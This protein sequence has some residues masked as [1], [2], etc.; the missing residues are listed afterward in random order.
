M[1]SSIPTP[2]TAGSAVCAATSKRPRAGLGLVL[3]ASGIEQ[4]ARLAGCALVIAGTALAGRCLDVLRA[5]AT[6]AARRA[7]QNARAVRRV[8]ATL[9]ALKGV[10]AKAGQFAALRHDLLPES[11]TAALAELRDRVPPLPFA[12]I[13]NTVENEL[14]APIEALFLEFERQPLGAASLA[15]VH[16]ARLPSGQPVAVKVQYPW[17]RAS[18]PAD[19]A[20]IRA[21][22]RA[23]TCRA[24]G[25]DWRRIVQEFAAGIADELDFRREARIA[26]EIAGNLARDPKIVVPEPIHSHTTER[27][28][29]MSY[30]PAVSVSDSARL[31]EMG[32][33]PT[34]VLEILARAYAKQVFADGLFHA[35]PHPGNLFVLDEPTAA[36][37]PRVLFIDFGLCRRLDPVLRN[38]MRR[39]IHALIQRDSDGF[40]D[41]MDRMGMIA[42]GARDGVSRAVG[43]MFER[44]GAAGGGLDAR[45]SR[46][47]ALKDEAKG[48]LQRTDGLQL[49]MDLLFYAKT[50][51]YVFALGAELAPNV[52][53]MK[54]SLPYLLQFL[55][56]KEE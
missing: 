33:E 3:R 35:D 42:P 56:Q 1:G 10:F 53:L 15:Q 32:V 52:D 39:G 45:G 37:Q 14:G 6:R 16:R 44:L 23:W 34:A 26:Q 13:R 7:A 18:L 55:A 5:P 29:T 22:L 50:V 11:A 8:V 43:E 27:V 12:R 49:P 21:F 48:L 47:L 9:G 41:G 17:L 2:A 54:L 19:L 28:L 46:V 24:R 25:I 51:S 30:R 38:E 4:L 20:L 31:A 36:Q 40:V